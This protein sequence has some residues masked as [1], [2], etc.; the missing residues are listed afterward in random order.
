MTFAF[1]SIVALGVW[2]VSRIIISYFKAKRESDKDEADRAREQADWD[3]TARALHA[4]RSG[5]RPSA[6]VDEDAWF[7]GADAL[8][9]DA[10]LPNI[11]GAE[12]PAWGGASQVVT[13]PPRRDRRDVRRP[14]WPWLAAGALLLSVFAGASFMLQLPKPAD[15]SLVPRRLLA[16]GL[17]VSLP[18]WDEH[19]TDES[20]AELTIG[21]EVGDRA[22]AE[23]RSALAR[24]GVRRTVLMRDGDADVLATVHFHVIPTQSR[25]P[26]V[27]QVQALLPEMRRIPGFVLVE[28]PRPLANPQIGDSCVFRIRKRLGRRGGELHEVESWVL[29]IRRAGQEVSLTLTAP[30]DEAEEYEPLFRRV[31]ASITPMTERDYDHLDRLLE[32]A[33]AARAE[34]SPPRGPAT[35]TAATAQTPAPALAAGDAERERALRL[36]LGLTAPAPTLAD[37]FRQLTE[38]LAAVIAALV[39]AKRLY[40]SAATT[41]ALRAQANLRIADA[42]DLFAS[43]IVDLPF[44]LPAA[45]F[46]DLERIDPGGRAEVERN[47]IRRARVVLAE[48]AASVFCLAAASYGEV[49]VED[50]V[51]RA[52]ARAQLAAYGDEF[53][54]GC[55]S[56]D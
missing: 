38:Q 47:V 33:V 9:H 39:E 35:R 48:K 45:F 55:A 53:I 25:T 22:V 13:Q 16:A 46:A 41:S 10:P 40:T 15:D 11:A 44:V 51:A 12:S 32:P 42:Y 2:F 31:F 52:R 19:I 50:T 5:E 27:E 1:M 8:A 24:A 6:V 56:T 3:A 34:P 30:A 17:I 20:A 36:P 26:E 7:S 43:R 29:F 23:G 14:S 37:T 49:S 18:D 54:A 28:G 21:S 4:Q